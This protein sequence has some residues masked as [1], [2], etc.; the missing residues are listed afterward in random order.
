MAD[1]IDTTWDFSFDSSSSD[2][3]L[4]AAYVRGA[5]M[6]LFA[7]F[8]DDNA[9]TA[10]WSIAS[11]DPEVF[12]IVDSHAE[13]T[14]RRVVAHGHAVRTGTAM[15][16]LLDAS[17]R[18]RLS[19][20][21]EVAVPDRVELDAAGPM[22][23]GPRRDAAVAE[24]RLVASGKGTFL[25]RYLLNGRELYGN[26]VLT[27]EV[28]SGVT[29]VPSTDYLQENREWLT[30]TTTE[31]GSGA[32]VLKAD[33]VAVTSVP[34]VV[35]PGSQVGKVIVTPQSEDGHDNGDEIAVTAQ[36]Y[37]RN[38]ER[39]FGTLYSW[40]GINGY[41]RTDQDVYLYVYD[42]NETHSLTA[43]Y[44]GY[45]GAA[46][47]HTR[48]RVQCSVGPG[49]SLLVGLVGLGLVIGRGRRRRGQRRGEP[50]SRSV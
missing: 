4:H 39:I 45:G 34:L 30:L 8:K 14:P 13:L 6:T 16:Q 15:L 32:L 48:E 17:G 18:E 9:K 10:G 11:S 36:A 40:Q 43:N 33:G 21:V 44:E 3:G 41:E 49:G 38:G 23:V 12:E 22:I 42:D 5:K 20:P 19:E 31:V 1:D 7:E 46:T 27:A 29:A 26:G 35:V 24:A 37:G 50:A 47:I 28:P 2:E 25:V